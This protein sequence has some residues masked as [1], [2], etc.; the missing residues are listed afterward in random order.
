MF[1]WGY[2]P[3]TR[4]YRNNELREQKAGSG[5]VDIAWAG[6]MIALKHPEY[7]IRLAETLK[8]AGIDFRL[9]MIGDG[10]MMNSLRQMV[11]NLSLT[12][13]VEFYGSM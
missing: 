9:H 6:R 2:F 3:A 1:Q 5:T 12:G 8:S 11:C 13:E 10:A 7:A 4:Y